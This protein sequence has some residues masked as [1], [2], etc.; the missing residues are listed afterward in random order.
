MDY[1]FWNKNIFEYFFSIDNA[2]TEI[3]FCVDD[4][5]INIVGKKNNVPS[6]INDFCQSVS[7]KIVFSSSSKNLIRLN[8]FKVEVINN[9]PSQTALIAF[10]ILA[11]TRMGENS[12][13]SQRAY[14]PY[15]RKLC[16]LGG[17]NNIKE[18]LYSSDT[19]IFKN[20]IF[21]NFSNY[22]N[23]N[24]VGK[25]GKIN[26]ENL[27]GENSNSRVGLP[28]YQSMISSND[29]ALLTKIF[30]LARGNNHNQIF[31]NDFKSNNYSRVFKAMFKKNNL[32]LDF[33][34]TLDKTLSLFF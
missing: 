23:I 7:K 21:K 11:A 24:C 16:E 34:G 25:L 15:L 20:N 32:I 33:D 1:E 31:S 27:Y 18:G 29:K 9:I 4:N 3:L 5:V 26:F 6:P 2:N 22:I 19:D 28:I 17:F 30:D 12:D 8:N 13:F 14:Y 10:F